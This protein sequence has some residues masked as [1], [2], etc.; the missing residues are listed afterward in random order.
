[1]SWTYVKTVLG[2]LQETH[3]SEYGKT[4]QK[5]LALTLRRLGYDHLE[6]RS[7]QGVDIDVMKQATGERLAFE[8]KTSQTAQITI[9][10]KDGRGLD[11]RRTDGYET[12]YAILCYPL[13]FSE[14]W[15][16]VPSRRIKPGRHQ[17]MALLR[18][19]DETLSQ[20]INALFPSIMEEI[21]P[22]LLQQPHGSL[23]RFLK[24][25]YKI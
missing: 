15:I 5:L 23:L 24:E 22:K 10:E 17:V 13:C 3:V 1:M 14:G 21:A 9:G 12:F 6:E 20:V 16:I 7:V 18:G 8:V 19:R 11:A 4:L 2:A 25:E